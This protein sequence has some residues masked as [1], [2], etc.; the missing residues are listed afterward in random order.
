[1]SRSA[2]RD[3]D[4]DYDRLNADWSELRA[5]VSP[6][7]ASKAARGAD[8]QLVMTG[9]RSAARLAAASALKARRMVFPTPPQQ[10]QQQPRSA[11]SHVSQAAAAGLTDARDE[12]ASYGADDFIEPHQIDQLQSPPPA[13]AAAAH[14]NAS[15]QQRQ[16]AS[17]MLMAGPNE[18][19]ILIDSN[20]DYS[21]QL[22]ALAYEDDG[23]S[24]A[25][26]SVR[27]APRASTM[28]DA[29]MSQNNADIDQAPQSLSDLRRSHRFGSAKH[30]ASAFRF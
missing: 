9:S 29:L 28:S 19:D 17:T 24:L 4:T 11:A 26:F 15:R 10:Q 18:R 30:L 22:A 12:D 6:T 13:A 14:R 21:T 20:D 8:G 27:K 25:A 1:M 5:I 3:L 7:P 23:E 16:P 2:A